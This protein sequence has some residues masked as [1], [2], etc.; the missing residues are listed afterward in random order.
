MAGNDACLKPPVVVFGRQSKAKEATQEVWF[1]IQQW[2][3]WSPN[4]PKVRMKNHETKS[5]TEQ[6]EKLLINNIQH[7]IPHWLVGIFSQTSSWS[8]MVCDFM[9]PKNQQEDF[10]HGKNLGI[11]DIGA[12]PTLQQRHHL[13]AIWVKVQG[14]YWPGSTYSNHNWGPQASRVICLQDDLKIPCQMGFKLSYSNGHGTG[15]C[16]FRYDIFQPSINV[17]DHHGLPQDEQNEAGKTW[18]ITVGNSI[19]PLSVGLAANLLPRYQPHLPLCG[20]SHLGFWESLYVQKKLTP[21][22]LPRKSYKL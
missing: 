6:N 20:K 2:L 22:R 18:K 15:S 14:C 9:G 3:T 10:R 16:L 19:K 5:P 12:R 8:K 11:P 7:T 21:M 13:E 4:R 17:G 1:P